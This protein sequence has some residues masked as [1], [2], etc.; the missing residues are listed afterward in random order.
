MTF[1][2]R[3]T[4]EYFDWMVD[5][6]CGDKRYSTISYDK[7]LMQLHDI[8]FIYTIP[9]DRNRAE[10]GADLRWRFVC[11]R[12][13]RDQTDDILEILDGP[14]S[15]LE[16]MIALAIRCEE[17][18]MDDPDI[19]DRTGQWFWGM[20]TNLGLGSMTDDRYDKQFVEDIVSK[21]LYREYE[22]DG[23]GG[24]FRVRGRGDLRTVNI[25]YQLSWYL[26]SI[27]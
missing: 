11:E 22:P 10:D 5:L 16:M 13:H 4:N 26:D 17:G 3:I 12:D 7:L 19:G 6:V 24:L 2:D 18:I 15:V 8:T 27:T 25:W 1:E 23:K 14:C 20:I 21:F 9:I